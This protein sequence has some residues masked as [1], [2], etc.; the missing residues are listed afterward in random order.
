MIEKQDAR[1]KL[2]CPNCGNE[3][4]EK[5]ITLPSDRSMNTECVCEICGQNFIENELIVERM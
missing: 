2:K 4:K 1:L 3:N 5:I